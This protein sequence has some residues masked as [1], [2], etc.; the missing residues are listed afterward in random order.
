METV[1]AIIF[2]SSVILIFSNIMHLQ[3]EYYAFVDGSATFS[4]H[5]DKLAEINVE[6]S[7]WTD[8]EILDS[9]N[10]IYQ[11][12]DRLDSYLSHL[13]SMVS[14]SFVSICDRKSLCREMYIMSKEKEGKLIDTVTIFVVL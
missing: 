9:I 11:N 3:S 8:C 7:K 2:F 6:R 10:M 4:L 1:S 5:F 12:L 14:L 13:V